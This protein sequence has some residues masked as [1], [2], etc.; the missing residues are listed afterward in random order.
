MWSNV[1]SRFTY[2]PLLI[3]SKQG[4]IF[5]RDN[6]YLCN[7]LSQLIYLICYQLSKVQ[8]YIIET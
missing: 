3:Q 7:Y 5:V 6:F 1:S 4:S 8:F 2:A